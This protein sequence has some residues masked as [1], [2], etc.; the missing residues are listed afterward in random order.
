MAP[1][2][3]GGQC[4]G[5]KSSWQN[6]GPGMINS[7]N[8]T[9]LVHDPAPPGASLVPFTLGAPGGVARAFHSRQEDNGD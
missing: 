3:P 4:N 9:R 7:E 8:S 6:A 5:P 2:R 1:E